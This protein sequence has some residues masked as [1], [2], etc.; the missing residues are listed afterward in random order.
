MKIIGNFIYFC[1]GAYIQE[2]TDFFNKATAILG[3]KIIEALY[4][5]IAN[6]LLTLIIIYIFTYLHY[7][8]LL[9]IY[10]KSIEKPSLNDDIRFLLKELKDFLKSLF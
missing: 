6:I 10:K 8:F 9:I 2:K 1:V 3:E 5:I 7:Y 4:T